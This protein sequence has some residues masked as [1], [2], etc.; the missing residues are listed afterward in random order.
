MAALRR[1]LNPL[2][3]RH[4]DRSGKTKQT[5]AFVAGFPNY[6]EFYETLRATTV[7]ATPLTIQRLQRIADAVA[8]PRDEIF[9]DEA[10]R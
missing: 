3:R 5:L 8:F 2:L 1:P 10:A 4:V 9:L 6:P 7:P